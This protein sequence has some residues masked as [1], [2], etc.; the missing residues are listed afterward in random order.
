MGLMTDT[1][2]L[3]RI[4]DALYHLG[5]RFALQLRWHVPECLAEMARC[6]SVVL[7]LSCL[8]ITSKAFGERYE[9]D[10]WV[11]GQEVLHE[12]FKSSAADCHGRL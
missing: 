12:F 8:F 10:G 7:C 11:I 3:V 1:P 4:V 5:Q 2:A 9:R 6:S